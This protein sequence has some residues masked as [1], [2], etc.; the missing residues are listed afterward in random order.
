M[1]YKK[2]ASWREDMRKIGRSL[3]QKMGWKREKTKKKANEAEC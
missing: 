1:G 3:D 2:Q